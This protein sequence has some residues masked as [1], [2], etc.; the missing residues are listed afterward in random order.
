MIVKTQTV[1]GKIIFLEELSLDK[2]YNHGQAASAVIGKVGAP[3]RKFHLLLSDQVRF[4]M[5]HEGNVTFIQP[6]F[7]ISRPI[8]DE[9]DMVV[10]SEDL[11]I[12]CL[13]GNY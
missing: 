12:F 6:T 3:S 1:Q 13:H 11:F 8:C 7:F 5:K 10:H 2:A 4:W 9:V